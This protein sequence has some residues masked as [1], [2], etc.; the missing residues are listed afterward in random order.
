MLLYLFVLLEKNKNIKIK[1]ETSS[2]KNKDDQSGWGAPGVDSE[3]VNVPGKCFPA[4]CSVGTCS[5]DLDLGPA[6]G[7]VRHL[8]SDLYGRVKP[9]GCPAYSSLL[10]HVGFLGLVRGEQ[11]VRGVT[12]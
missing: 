5:L 10:R 11:S 8:V 9:L 12:A 1:I 2:S 6:G 3:A 7:Y 4:F